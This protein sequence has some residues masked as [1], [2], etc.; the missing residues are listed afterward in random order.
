ML[1]IFGR[2]GRNGRNHCV[3]AVGVIGWWEGGVGG[4]CMC[5]VWVS[6]VV[7]VPRCRMVGVLRKCGVC[8]VGGG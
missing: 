6:V 4:V 8:G 2:D 1:L 7:V 5:W 3:A